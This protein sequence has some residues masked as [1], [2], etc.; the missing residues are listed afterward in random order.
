MVLNGYWQSEKHWVEFKKEI[1]E[2]FAFPWKLNEGYVSVH[3]RRTDFITLKEKHPVVTDEWYNEA[4][5]LFQNKKF[6]FFSD[7]ID[8]CKKVWGHR[9]D[10]Y[11]SNVSI[12]QDMIDMSCCEGHICSASTYAFW[13]MYLNRNED[14][15]V[16]FPKLWFTPGWDGADTKDVLPEWVIKL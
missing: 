2:L 9:S 6:L 4:M 10:C 7:E 15:K 12:E 14:K 1:V 5:A 3:L 8:Y 13:G 11:F 16:I